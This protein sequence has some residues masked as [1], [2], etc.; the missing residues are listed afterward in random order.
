ME[1]AIRTG[2]LKV[3]RKGKSM[4]KQ[5]EK[6]TVTEKERLTEMLKEILMVKW[7]ER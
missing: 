5:R 3:I 6:W 4:E 2:K 1:M 7:K